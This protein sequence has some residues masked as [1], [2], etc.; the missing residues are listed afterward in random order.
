M[1]F[2]QEDFDA[3]KDHPITKDFFA[4][5]EEQRETLKEQWAGGAFTGPSIEET[6]IRN[7]AATGA[8]SAYDAV[9]ELDFD[10]LNGAEHDQTER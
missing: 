6:T 5:V 1:S 7:S 8:A 10:Q 3:W 9:L 4:W 2:K